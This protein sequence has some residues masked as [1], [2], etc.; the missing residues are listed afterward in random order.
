MQIFSQLEAMAPE[1]IHMATQ[2]HQ[3]E[4]IS[5][6]P[7]FAKKPAVDELLYELFPSQ[8]PDPSQV[9]PCICALIVTDVSKSG[10][11]P[12]PW[13]LKLA[14]YLSST[15]YVFVHAEAAGAH[16]VGATQAPGA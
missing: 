14:F 12:G 13:S 11:H 15:L 8:E 3:E 9:G 6:P 10:H 5:R 1:I 2:A 16:E 7:S 4:G